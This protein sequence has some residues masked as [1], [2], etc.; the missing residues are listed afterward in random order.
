MLGNRL[1]QHC[2]ISEYVPVLWQRQEAFV[3][4]QF[5]RI[6]K[7]LLT[8]YTDSSKLQCAMKQNPVSNSEV[9]CQLVWFER[10]RCLQIRA[11]AHTQPPYGDQDILV[12]WKL[13]LLIPPNCSRKQTSFTL[14][15]IAMLM[16]PLLLA[17]KTSVIFPWFMLVGLKSWKFKQ[18]HRQPL[19][20]TSPFISSLT[21]LLIG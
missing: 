8:E 16:F 7:T 4:L 2:S 10:I 9:V 18:R 5:T 20:A 13:S 17:K 21:R 15:L 1:P 6:E 14:V 12:I 11:H 3:A 19:P